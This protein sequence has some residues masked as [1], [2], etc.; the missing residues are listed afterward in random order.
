MQSHFTVERQRAKH[1]L[2]KFDERRAQNTVPMATPRSTDVNQIA[3]QRQKPKADAQRDLERQR[4]QARNS[5]QYVKHVQ[6]WNVQMGN[7]LNAK[8]RRLIP[9]AEKYASPNHFP[10]R[11]DSSYSAQYKHG[12]NKEIDKYREALQHGDVRSTGPQSSSPWPAFSFQKRLHDVRRKTPLEEAPLNMVT[13]VKIHKQ[14][15][16]ELGD[17]DFLHSDK[18]CSMEN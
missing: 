9:E 7:Q 13:N 17:Q 15:E 1:A 14:V 16:E 3:E 5:V 8:E 10:E 18:H 11:R 2:D 6:K 4:E 12:A